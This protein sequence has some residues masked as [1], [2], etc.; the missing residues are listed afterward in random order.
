M[1]VEDPNDA[2]L[3]ALSAMKHWEMAPTEPGAFE[4]AG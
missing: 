2:R 1:D 3:V 4:K